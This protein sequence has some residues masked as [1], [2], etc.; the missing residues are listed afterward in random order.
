MPA[1][2]CIYLRNRHV[3]DRVLKSMAVHGDRNR[4]EAAERMIHEQYQREQ[5]EDE[6]EKEPEPIGK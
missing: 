2:K 5:T 4:T 3:V 1:Q 6:F